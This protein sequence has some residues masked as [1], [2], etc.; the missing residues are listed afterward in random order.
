MAVPQESS[1][2]PV[3]LL[4]VEQKSESPYQRGGGQQPTTTVP[5]E[6]APRQRVNIKAKIIMTPGRAKR[7]PPHMEPHVITDYTEVRPPLPH[8]Y[9]ENTCNVPLVHKYNTRARSLKGK[10]LTA[11]HV[12]TIMPP[13][14]LPNS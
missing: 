6:P 9:D 3:H 14:Q 7:K 10:N 4:S 8:P 2:P 1:T 5:P 12:E 13:I 11:K